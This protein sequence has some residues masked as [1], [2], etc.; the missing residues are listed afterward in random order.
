MQL[1]YISQSNTDACFV[2]GEVHI[3]FF[4]VSHETCVCVCVASVDGCCV[5]PLHTGNKELPARNI[6]ST[7]DKRQNQ[8]C[9]KK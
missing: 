4:Q 5:F 9:N 2:K 8:Q 7:S 3:F 6:L 1:G